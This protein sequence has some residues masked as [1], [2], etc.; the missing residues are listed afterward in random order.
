MLIAGLQKLTLIDYPEKLATLIFTQGCNFACDYC[1]NAEMIPQCRMKP[2]DP[3]LEPQ[4]IL[5]FL[6]HRQGLIDGVVIS[7]GEPTLQSDLQAFIQQ[8]K[9]LGYLVKL[10][11][12]GSNPNVLKKLIDANLLNY[13]L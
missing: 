6:K 5:N 1:H 7:G 11:T 2:F 10:D 9:K 12:N 13:I 8:I 4:A 3:R